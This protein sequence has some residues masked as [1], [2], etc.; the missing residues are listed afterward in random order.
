MIEEL[1]EER[2]E[3]FVLGEDVS[4]QPGQILTL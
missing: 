1:C 3:E 4:K 2:T